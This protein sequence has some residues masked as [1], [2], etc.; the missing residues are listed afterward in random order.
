MNKFNA[1]VRRPSHGAITS[2]NQKTRRDFKMMLLNYWIS[3]PW[4]WPW[5]SHFECLRSQ[6]RSR[7]RSRNTY[8]SNAS[9][10]NWWPRKDYYFFEHETIFWSDVAEISI[11]WPWPW[12]WSR[13]RCRIT[14]LPVTDIW[15]LF[16]F[17]LAFL[18]F[19]NTCTECLWPVTV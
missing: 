10:V 7:S 2:Q 19:S 14:W 1:R 13:N 16:G 3:I 8:F 5:V 15:P 12:L 18:T 4:P 17:E 9:W 6:S 11:P